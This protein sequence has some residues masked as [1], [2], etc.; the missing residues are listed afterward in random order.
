[1]NKGAECSIIV[2]DC[3]NWQQKL[4][5]SNCISNSHSLKE[6]EVYRISRLQESGLFKCY[7]DWPEELKKNTKKLATLE[8]K[9]EVRKGDAFYQN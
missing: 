7:P 4:I 9:L 8:I 5:G 3:S 2:Q 6:T 1:M